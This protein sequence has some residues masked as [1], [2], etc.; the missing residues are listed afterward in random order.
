SP[1]LNDAARP[2]EAKV[3]AGDIAI[4][5]RERAAFLRGHVRSLSAG[6]LLVSVAAEPRVIDLLRACGNDVGYGEVECHDTALRCSSAAHDRAQ[7]APPSVFRE[8]TV[9]PG[10]KAL[11]RPTKSRDNRRHP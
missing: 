4:P 5:H 8:R 7:R 11:S 6:H 10:R 2:F 3:A 9:A 1:G